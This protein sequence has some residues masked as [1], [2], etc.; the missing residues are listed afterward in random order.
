[1]PQCS[2]NSNNMKQVLLYSFWA[3]AGLA[4]LV[5]C[6]APVT[7]E[8][9]EAAYYT[10]ITVVKNL[11]IDEAT[12][13]VYL[14]RNDTLLQTAAITFG[15]YAV[16]FS[17]IDGF[18][19]RTFASTDSVPSQ[20]YRCVIADGTRFRDSVTL[21]VPANL[22]ITDIALP[23]DR[24]N[25]GGAD[26]QLQWSLSLTSDNYVFAVNHIDSLYETDGYAD[27][28]PSGTAQATVPPDAFRPG[29][30]SDPILGW[31]Y[32]YAYAY[33]GVPTGDTYLP[34][35]FPAG[36]TNNIAKTDIVG[37]YGVVVIS[38]RDS[39]DVTTGD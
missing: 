26:V 30:I 11:D 34:T 3:L 13:S 23:E 12:V 14:T 10:E 6:D 37:S 4:C 35:T 33:T 5:G 9:E 18:Y 39:I 29:G 15:G 32:V 28:S 17:A 8:N 21:T 38:P 2:D 31:Y 22:G 16:N 19:K 24:V 36:L 1:M 7:T 27:F 20:T 25:P